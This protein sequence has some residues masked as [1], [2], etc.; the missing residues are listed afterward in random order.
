VTTNVE[1]KPFLP[2][3]NHGC[4]VFSRDAGERWHSGRISPPPGGKGRRRCLL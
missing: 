3:T 4:T 1:A 2:E